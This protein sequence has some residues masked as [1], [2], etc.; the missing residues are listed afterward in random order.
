MFSNLVQ[1]LTRLWPHGAP[2]ARAVP[3]IELD[4]PGWHA[5][6]R[7]WARGADAIQLP[8]SAAASLFPDTQPAFHGP[9]EDVQRAA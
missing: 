8:P 3:D 4:E 5:S 6:G 9:S 7:S 2:S 1:Q